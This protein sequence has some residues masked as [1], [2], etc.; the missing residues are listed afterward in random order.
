VLSTV[1]SPPMICDSSLVMVR[2]R[3]LPGAPSALAIAAALEGIEDALEIIGL[4]ADAA[5]GDFELG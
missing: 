1:I 5:V 2:P 4:D 3:P